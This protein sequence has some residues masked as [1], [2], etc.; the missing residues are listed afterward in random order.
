MIKKVDRC[1]N[2]PAESS[3]RKISEHTFCGYFLPFDHKENKHD[4]YRG[5]D[6]MIKFYESLR[7]DAMK[8][9]N[10]EKK[11][12]IPLTSKKYKSYLNLGNCHSCRKGLNIMHC[13]KKL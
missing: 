10:F 12:M 5:E 7:E 2:N 6:W 13:W 3:T 4:V 9:I 1:R 8:I 11:E